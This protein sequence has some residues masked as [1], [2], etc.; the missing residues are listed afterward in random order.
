MTANGL[1]P[2]YVVTDLTQPL[3][4]DPGFDA[5]LRRRTPAGRWA[6]PEE[7]IGTL[8]WLAAPGLGFRQ[9]AGHRR[10]RGD[11]RGGLSG[12]A[13]GQASRRGRVNRRGHGCWLLTDTTSPVMY[14]A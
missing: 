10:G 2:G 8:V 12:A 4:D 3:V 7:L 6:Q 9:R 11:D 14:E 5:W 1:A 13:R